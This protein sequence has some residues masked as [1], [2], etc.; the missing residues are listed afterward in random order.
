M[1][2]LCLSVAR[3]HCC[4]SSSTAK[5]VLKKAAERGLLTLMEEEC[6]GGP[7]AWFLW[8]TPMK[9]RVRELVLHIGANKERIKLKMILSQQC[10]LC[11]RKPQVELQ[12]VLYRCFSHDNKALGADSVFC[13]ESK[14]R[15]I[16]S[17]TGMG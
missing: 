5:M 17:Q 13:C 16:T 2:R 4:W 11:S 12:L 1:S 10:L 15:S 9:H 14:L 8:G 6:K 3:L 7:G